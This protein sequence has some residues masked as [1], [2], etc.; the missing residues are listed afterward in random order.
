MTL[1]RLFS[2]NYPNKELCTT[3]SLLNENLD[4]VIANGSSQE[5]VLLIMKNLLDD[6]KV[7]SSISEYAEEVIDG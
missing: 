3:L 5:D 7:C 6:I 4:K 2:I 1:A